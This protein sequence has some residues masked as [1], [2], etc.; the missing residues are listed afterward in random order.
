MPYLRTY[1]ALETLVAVTGISLTIGLPEF[2]RF[3]LPVTRFASEY[4]SLIN[5]IRFLVAFTAL[6]VPTTAMGAT[7][8]VL[9]AALAE[10]GGEFG[11]VLGRLYGWNT[12]GAVGG[13]VVAEIVLVS[14]FGITGSA[15]IGG[16]L[17]LVA[18][19]AAIW[20]VQGAREDHTT[21]R[22]AIPQSS[23]PS[24]LWRPLFSAFLAGA[25]L[26]A[27]EIVWFRFLLMFRQ[28][29]AGD[30]PDS[31]GR[32]RRHR[33]GRASGIGVAETT[34]RRGCPV[35]DSRLRRR[36]CRRG[37]L[38]DFSDYHS[39]RLGDGVVRDSMVRRRAHAGN[40]AAVGRLL[41][42][43]RRGHQT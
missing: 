30:Q 8:P 11:Q 27:L 20:V 5:L 37:R 9:V 22:A 15:W 7:L 24:Q 1:A 29:H 10:T 17:N 32:A 33:L 39:R 25:N 43:A 26:M 31:S 28:Q 40:L 12:L 3:L 34:P 36:V 14:H 13:A 16:S 23:L 2:T 4:P 35:A 19:G 21:E 42:L 38:S 41:D 6:I 18:A